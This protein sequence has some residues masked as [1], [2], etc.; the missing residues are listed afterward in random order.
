MEAILCELSGLPLPAPMDASPET[1]DSSR[2]T[3]EEYV[4]YIT[5]EVVQNMDGI[6]WARVN[7]KTRNPEL[8]QNLEV[9]ETDGGQRRTDPDQNVSSLMSTPGLLRKIPF[10]FRDLAQVFEHVQA[11]GTR[12]TAFAQDLAEFFTV[13]QLSLSHEAAPRSSGATKEFLE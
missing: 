1:L 3:C 2:L 6:A 8:Y 7:R 12:S 9:L 11:L 4:A 13:Q 10:P 5:W